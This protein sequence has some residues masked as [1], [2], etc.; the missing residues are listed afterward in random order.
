M[1]SSPAAASSWCR[2]SSPTSGGVVVSYFEW[3][4]NLQRY[5]WTEEEVN[6]KLEVAMTKAFNAVYDR[7]IALDTTLR[8]GAYRGAERIVTAKKLRG[9]R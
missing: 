2:I 3:V 9:T 4:Q 7:A 5:Y 6:Q 8:L 1:P